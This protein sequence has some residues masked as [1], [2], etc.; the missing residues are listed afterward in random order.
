MIEMLF[1]GL[2]LHSWLP[3]AIVT[4][5]G[6]CVLS[7]CR[8]SAPAL[9]N[10]YLVAELPNRNN[11]ARPDVIGDSGDPQRVAGEYCNL[12]NETR[13]LAAIGSYLRYSG[14]GTV[15]ERS[16][17]DLL[18]S[19][20]GKATLQGNNAIAWQT[21]NRG[22]LLR[23]AS[24]S[25]GIAYLDSICI[26]DKQAPIKY[27]QE[28]GLGQL[29]PQVVLFGCLVMLVSA[30]ASAIVKRLRWLAVGTL[31]T[32]VSTVVI[33]VQPERWGTS[34]FTGEFV[35]VTS[36]GS[37]PWF[38]AFTNYILIPW[39]LFG[40]LGM[41][42]FARKQFAGRWG[43]VAFISLLTGM[44][45]LALFVVPLVLGGPITYLLAHKS[46]GRTQCRSCKSWVNDQASVCP[47]CRSVLVPL[48]R[49]IRGLVW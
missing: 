23:F 49:E 43:T 15:N 21:A 13:Y 32:V 24:D 38:E 3:K 16:I 29:K 31:A 36:G 41:A 44:L 48:K 2:T 47:H 19:S 17:T 9:D 42:T 46:S 7:A 33:F 6:V 12:S 28:D 14:P 26:Y 5:V 27:R 22:V 11:G 39:L 45:G 4:A 25:R 40:A 8:G 35:P 20:Y 1:R 10:S 18:S 37:S 30:L 34:I